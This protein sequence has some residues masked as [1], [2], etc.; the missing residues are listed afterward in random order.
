VPKSEQKEAEPCKDADEHRPEGR[1]HRALN[2]PVM[3][4]GVKHSGSGKSCRTWNGAVAGRL[5]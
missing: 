2:R 4:C 3:R 5:T 1:C